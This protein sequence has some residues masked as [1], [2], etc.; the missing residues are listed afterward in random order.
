VSDP[1]LSALERQL[2]QR[3]R[4]QRVTQ[5]PVE[6]TLGG[7]SLS[8][9]VLRIAEA[10]A[11]KSY[12]SAKVGAIA[13]TEA[14]GEAIV[15][16]LTRVLRDGTDEMLDV[17]LRYDV[18]ETIPGRYV[19]DEAGLVR[20]S[21]VDEH[22]TEQEVEDAFLAVLTVGLPFGRRAKTL[23]DSQ[24]WMGLLRAMRAL[25]S[26]TPTTPSSPSSTS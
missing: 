4:E 5:A 19:D 22:A 24:D 2:P 3:T 16:L 20:S 25:Q 21:W 8:L 26:S 17:V 12:T 11:W 7:E 14:K 10:R 18:D 9:R 1:K 6:L 15:E 23:I 13:S